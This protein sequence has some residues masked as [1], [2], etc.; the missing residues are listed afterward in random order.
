[1]THKDFLKMSDEQIRKMLF[2][3]L[4]NASDIRRKQLIEA[5]IAQIDFMSMTRSA[6]T[7]ASGWAD[8]KS[9]KLREAI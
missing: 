6:S 1:M 2:E 3:A 8:M 4:S 9:S 7:F 5:C